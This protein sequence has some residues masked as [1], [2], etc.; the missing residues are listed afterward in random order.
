MLL[1]CFRYIHK[2]NALSRVLHEASAFK[3]PE[4]IILKVKQASVV[5]VD[6]IGAVP[7]LYSMVQS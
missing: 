3:G 4:E 5:A 6:K 2:P 1:M 7:A